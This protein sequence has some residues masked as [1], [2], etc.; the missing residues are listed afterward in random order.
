MNPLTSISDWHTF[1]HRVCFHHSTGSKHHESLPMGAL[2]YHMLRSLYVLKTMYSCVTVTNVSVFND[3]RDHIIEH[4]WQF[5]EEVQWE[6]NSVVSSFVGN[7]ACGCTGNCDGSRVGSQHCFRYCIQCTLK[8]KCKLNC[9][10]PHNDG[11]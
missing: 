7:K 3:S 8:C 2:K 4:G 9:K 1:T 6:D 10:N 5:V 11:D